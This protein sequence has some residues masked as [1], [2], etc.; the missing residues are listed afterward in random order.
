MADPA[1]SF[2]WEYPLP[3]ARATI[4]WL[5]GR[6][7]EPTLPLSGRALSVGGHIGNWLPAFIHRKCNDRAKDGEQ[8]LQTG[9][10]EN[11]AIRLLHSHSNC[12]TP[13]TSPGRIFCRLSMLLAAAAQ[14]GVDAAGFA[15]SPYA[16]A[17]LDEIR[18]RVRALRSQ[19]E[20]I[21]PQ[22]LDQLCSSLHPSTTP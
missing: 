17:L 5:D 16:A 15:R 8:H 1:R 4:R 20:T 22:P 7:C 19:P 2:D 13:N 11:S 14:P 6:Q 9:G 12:H 18:Q 21:L 10:P 3:Q